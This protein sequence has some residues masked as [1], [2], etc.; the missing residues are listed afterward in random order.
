MSEAYIMLLAQLVV[1]G[2]LLGTLYALMACGLNMILGVMFVVNFAHGEIIMLGA[3][4]T[5]WLYVAN[6]M[7]P[8]ASLLV[9]VPMMFIVGM[10]LQRFLF[11]R[12]VGEANHLNSLLISFGL[13]ILI[14]S[15]AMVLWSANYRSVPYF[16]GSINLW[17]I[18]LPQSR[19]VT[20][21]VAL[22]LTAAAYVFLRSSRLGKAIR[23]TAQNPD[24]A[25][26]CG[27]DIKKIRMIT[28]GLGTAMGAA[29]GS[30][31]SAMYVFNPDVGSVFILRAF[32]IVIIG[33][34]GSFIGA[35][36]G[37][38]ILGVAESVTSLLTSAQFAEIAAYLMIILVLLIRPR[39]IMGVRQ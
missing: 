29:A 36:I 21:A 5:Y 11:E 37:A 6:I 26:A 32:A 38:L 27:I 19:L 33:G 30:L 14:A 35:F 3:F 22:A 10:V 34:L 31:I 1:S 13:S 4:V 17:G 2:L 20:A 28:F 9:T 18:A 39:G 12:V 7:G 23:A 8:V 16:S 24:A 25:L 15:T